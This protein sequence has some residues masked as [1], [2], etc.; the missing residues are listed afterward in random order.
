[1]LALAQCLPPSPSH[2]CLQAIAGA[3]VS[4][5]HPPTLLAGIH[6]PS[7]T[8]QAKAGAGSATLSMAYA[9]DRFAEACLRAMSGEGG[10]VV[11]CAYVASTL[12]TG[13]PFFASQLRLGPAGI[14]GGWVGGWVGGWGGWGLGGWVRRPPHRHPLRGCWTT[15][16][17]VFWQASTLQPQL[18]TQANNPCP[19]LHPPPA[20]LPARP[21]VR[22]PARP[23]ACRVPAAATPECAGAGELPG[24]AG[25]AAGQHPE[26][27]GI[28][29]QVKKPRVF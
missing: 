13:L 1:M 28:H 24:H 12:V 9:A 27:S 19:C 18:S 26:G 4:P 5:T 11:E 20:C 25:T 15:W 29:E 22:L 3:A 17:A 21:P 8:V 6:S 16:A 23:P 14:A 10:D 2:T 7:I